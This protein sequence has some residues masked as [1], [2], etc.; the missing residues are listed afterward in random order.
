M[1]PTVPRRV[2]TTLMTTCRVALKRYG[3]ML[4]D[5]G[6]SWFIQ[7][8]PEAR[9]IDPELDTLKTLRGSDFEAVYTGANQY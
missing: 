9:W 1:P 2:A 5:N 8:S 3:M 6:Q 7:G 4:A